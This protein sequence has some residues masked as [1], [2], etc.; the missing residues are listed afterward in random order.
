MN[1]VASK[2]VGR[3]EKK[4]KQQVPA[5]AARKMERCKQ[6]KKARAVKQCRFTVLGREGDVL[7]SFFFFGYMRLPGI[8]TKKKEKRSLF[9]PCFL[10]EKKNGT[11]FRNRHVVSSLLY[12]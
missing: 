7:A 3:E 2:G 1:G 9:F 5:T 8:K 6:R 12:A 4:K 11:P 10:K